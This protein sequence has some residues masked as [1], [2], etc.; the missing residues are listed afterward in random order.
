M[1]RLRGAVDII[2]TSEIGTLRDQLFVADLIRFAGLYGANHD[3]YGPE[4]VWGTHA[5]YGAWQEPTQSSKLLT[6]ASQFRIG[7]LLEVG[8]W[9]GCWAVFMTAYFK[10]FN[11]DIRAI[12][13]DIADT[14]LPDLPT[15]GGSLE[16]QR[17]SSDAF[18]GQ[19][20]DMAFIDGGRDREVVM[21]HWD[22]VGKHAGLCVFHDINCKFAP[23]IGKI[24]P[25]LPSGVEKFEILDHASGLGYPVMGVGVIRHASCH[26]LG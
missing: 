12:S 24:W 19:H 8:S 18:K 4:Q 2:N 10:K 25:T 11:P 1:N 16:F 5:D 20:F 26:R 14:V 9:N 6:W 22:N 3:V 17:A 13:I 23:E 15:V 21:G 7:S